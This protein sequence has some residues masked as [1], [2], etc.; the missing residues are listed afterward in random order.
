MRPRRDRL[1]PQFAHGVRWDRRP[2]PAGRVDVEQV[3]Q[4]LLKWV[5]LGYFG[6][7]VAGDG[8]QP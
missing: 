5:G 3:E 1:G 2:V 7:S 8:S 4:A 6:D